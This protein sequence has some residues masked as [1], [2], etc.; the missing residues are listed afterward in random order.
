MGWGHPTSN[1][2]FRR[3]TQ[4]AKN[5]IPHTL[6]DKV[7]V[8][9]AK[10]F[11]YVSPNVSPRKDEEGGKGGAGGKEKE[12]ALSPRPPRGTQGRGTNGR[13]AKGGKEDEARTP[14]GT[15]HGSAH[16]KHKHTIEFAADKKEEQVSEGVGG[17]ER[18]GGGG[19]RHD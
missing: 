17:G 12:G 8:D 9:S 7:D 1:S 2:L 5:L 18:E 11:G 4:V 14:R 3:Y 19:W 10:T 15:H 16:H 6:A 13:S